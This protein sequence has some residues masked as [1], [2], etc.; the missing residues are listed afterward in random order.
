MTRE[1]TKAFL[2]RIKSHYSEFIIDQ[3][4]FDEWYKELKDYDYKEVNEKLEQHLRSEEFGDSVPKLYFLTRYLTKTSEKKEAKYYKSNCRYC[5]K[6]IRTNQDTEEE[7][8]KHE[9]RCR[10]VDY[11]NKKR[12]EY[13]GQGIDKEKYRNLPQ[14]DFDSRYD[15]VLEYV[16]KHTEDAN[17]KKFIGNCLE[18]K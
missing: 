5:N 11:M 8:R 10:S 1:Q 3:F 9:N 4:K 16:Y 17:E 7:L 2:H 18:S 14:A 12:I 15:A 6:E 13:K